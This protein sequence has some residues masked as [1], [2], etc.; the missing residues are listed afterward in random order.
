MWCTNP[1]YPPSQAQRQATDT[2]R[3]KWSGAAEAGGQAW[4]S[5]A[6]TQRRTP[7]RLPHGRI[8]EQKKQNY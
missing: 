7:R 5:D 4:T 2:L 3:R 1:S 6:A 8:A